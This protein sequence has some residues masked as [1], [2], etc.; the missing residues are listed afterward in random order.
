LHLKNKIARAI[1]TFFVP[2]SFTII[3]FTL[4][5]F[6]FE[7]EIKN[8]IIVILTAFS[9]GFL[10]HILF[11]FYLRKK[12][13]LSDEDASIKEERTY[14]YIIASF[15]YTAGFL[16]LLLFDVNIISIAFWFCYISNTILIMIINKFWKISAH[17]MGAAGPAAALTFITGWQFIFVI[18]LVLIISWARVQLKLHNIPQVIAGALTGFIS[19]FLQ[20]HFI[21]NSF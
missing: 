11:F 5:A 12:G 21:I 20:M 9:F 1:S 6:L 14:P 8:R 18:L 15:F 7:T 2:P 17:T 10:F 4:F 13:L 16:I 19:T 3:L